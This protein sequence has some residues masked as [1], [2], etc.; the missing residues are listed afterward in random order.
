MKNKE[1]RKELIIGLV[2]AMLAAIAIVTVI[3]L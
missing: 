3:F 1:Y 2:F